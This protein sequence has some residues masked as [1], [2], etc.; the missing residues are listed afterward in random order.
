MSVE[1]DQSSGGEPASSEGRRFS[2]LIGSL[3]SATRAGR[4]AHADQAGQAEV[5]PTAPIP[6]RPTFTARANGPATA[7]APGPADVRDPRSADSPGDPDSAGARV[8]R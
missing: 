3:A 8:R 1:P 5:Q 7:V 2:T 4:T 6:A